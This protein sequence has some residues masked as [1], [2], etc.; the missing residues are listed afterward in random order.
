MSRLM[1]LPLILGLAW[2]TP[3]AAQH[4]DAGPAGA[5][6]AMSTGND[7][8]T[9]SRDI[10][11]IIQRSCQQCHRPDGIGPMPLLT[12]EQT[13]PFAPLIRYRVEQRIMPPCAPRQD[14][15]HPGVRKT[16]SRS[17]TKRSPPS[18]DGPTPARPRATLPTC[19]RP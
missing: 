4:A 1:T 6:V 14:S 9:W 3:T 15:G 13:V 7:A 5:E 18:C 19:H 12:Y 2:G 10:A 11:P 8:P 16:T 17:A